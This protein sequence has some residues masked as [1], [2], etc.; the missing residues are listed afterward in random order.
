MILLSVQVC[1][2]VKVPHDWG[3]IDVN[4]DSTVLQVFHG[5]SNGQV[6]CADYFHL[7]M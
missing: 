2:G 3:V 5:L 6:E 4:G 1:A 7:I